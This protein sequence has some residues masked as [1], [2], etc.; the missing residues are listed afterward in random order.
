MLSTSD[1]ESFHLSVADGAA[2]G[3]IPVILPWK[4]SRALYSSEWICDDTYAASEYILSHSDSNISKVIEDGQRS[5]SKDY[6]ITQVTRE[7]ANLI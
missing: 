4:G 2:S 5:I 1:H 3:A 6:S 7:W